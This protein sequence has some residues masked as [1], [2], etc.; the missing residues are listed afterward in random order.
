[1][2]FGKNR[3]DNYANWNTSLSYSL[4]EHFKANLTYGYFINWSTVPFADFVR[5]SWGLN[6]SSRW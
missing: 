5:N 4:N 1:V 2:V 3:H 6:F